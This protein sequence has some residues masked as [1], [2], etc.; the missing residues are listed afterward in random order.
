M[1]AAEGK[2]GWRARYTPPAHQALNGVD[3][4]TQ[5]GFVLD[6]HCNR[7][8]IA[9]EI[10]SL[11]SDVQRV[12]QLSHGKSHQ[13]LKGLALERIPPHLDGRLSGGMGQADVEERTVLAVVPWFS[14]RSFTGLV[15]AV[16]LGCKRFRPSAE[17]G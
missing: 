14:R 10:R 2:Y 7:L 13:K 9:V 17:L 11:R 6:F 1:F 3:G 16:H 4:E 5:A 12:K 15:Q 8:P